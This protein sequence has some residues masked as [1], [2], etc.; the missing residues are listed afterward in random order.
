MLQGLVA[1]RA[2]SQFLDLYDR[3]HSLDCV[4]ATEML[5]LHCNSIWAGLGVIVDQSILIVDHLIVA[6]R[7]GSG[8]VALL[9]ED[10]STVHVLIVELYVD[11]ALVRVVVLIKGD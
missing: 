1:E 10:L 6:G 3:A 9:D 5:G 2:S 4:R 7:C 11:G 8:L